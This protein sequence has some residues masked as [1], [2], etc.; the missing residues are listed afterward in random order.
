MPGADR[1]H[2]L[3][4]LP[5]AAPVYA[6]TSWDQMLF[7]S[8]TP[9]PA[10]H[11]LLA[12]EAGRLA[13]PL[14]G[15]GEPALEMERRIVEDQASL[16]DDDGSP[17]GWGALL[18]PEVAPDEASVD[19][20]AGSP[21]SRAKLQLTDARAFVAERFLPENMTLLIAGGIGTDTLDS[22]VAMLPRALR[23][24]PAGG[25]RKPRVAE[26]AADPEPATAAVHEMA[27]TPVP[28]LLRPQLLLTWRLPAAYSPDGLS[29]L[30]ARELL[31]RRLVDAKLNHRDPRIVY[32]RL[33]PQMNH[34]GTLFVVEVGLNDA[35]DADKTAR[36]VQANV[37]GLAS[38]L[39]T[40]RTFE[41]RVQDTRVVAALGGM[42]PV[43]R[44][45]MEASWASG[46]GQFMS[47]P[48][49][50][51][52][53]SATTWPSV[54]ALA[55][56]YLTVPPH[57]V[58]RTPA[59]AS[60]PAAAER[61]SPLS[62]SPSGLSPTGR[63][64]ITDASTWDPAS[65]QGLVP[66]VGFANARRWTLPNG[67]TVVYLRQ[68]GQQRAAAWLGFRGGF[69]SGP[70]PALV[71]WAH[72]FRPSLDI[73]AR[74][75]GV[76][77]A[78]GVDADTSYETVTFR[79]AQIVDA[80]RL[81]V[82]RAR[83]RAQSWPA[84][85]DLNRQFQ[86]DPQNQPGAQAETTFWR[87]LF[88]DH[89]YGRVVTRADSRAVNP[90]AATAWLDRV[91]QPENAALVVVGDLDESKLA[92][93]SDGLAAG[94]I[95]QGG[96]A[97]PGPPPPRLRSVGDGPSLA[98]VDRPHLRMT[99]LRLGCVLP[100]REAGDRA[101]HSVLAHAIEAR[102]YNDLRHATGILQDVSVRRRDPRNGGDLVLTTAVD[103]TRLAPVL[104]TFRRSW[105]RWGRSQ[106]AT[107]GFDLAETNLGK[108]RALGSYAARH[109][110]A[111]DL[112]R[113]LFNQW[114]QDLPFEALDAQPAQIVAATPADL[115]SLFA[116]CRD[117]ATMVILGD[118]APVEAALAEAWP[119]HPLAG[120]ANR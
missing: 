113:V 23:D 50:L 28:S 90:E 32:T 11:E 115:T 48:R 2:R 97:V 61:A 84:A 45:T 66:P 87:N 53:L 14:A 24:A 102:L 17:G 116:V 75:R 94:W 58:L 29:M 118:R 104:R 64:P 93:I 63:D 92:V 3:L 8:V 26:L 91:V 112:A 55:F 39:E 22:V 12:I 71:K 57:V 95:S 36:L 67:L 65:L 81:L 27:I 62:A 21:A 9:S 77:A 107:D 34:R 44:A 78:R 5:I 83:V 16:R 4:H 106:R 108:W 86:D 101:L 73:D 52:A 99:Y 72:E 120:V 59:P 37:T 60:P 33:R 119:L 82:R 85:E 105:E 19:D 89:P 110:S 47:Q 69:A 42:P 1:W 114:V 54:A 13:R 56:K 25:A 111:H 117:N 31:T 6:T 46:S 88:P 100:R 10:W 74:Q 96:S 35:S 15:V 7:R 51:A 80:L 109:E 40:R 49:Y 103:S 98:I 38:D 68:P 70:S 18:G 43:G 79:P 20:V 76:L 41:R 30:W